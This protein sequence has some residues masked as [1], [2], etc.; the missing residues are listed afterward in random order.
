MK[1]YSVHDE[2]FRQYGRTVAC[3]FFEHFA[4]EA[5]KIALPE[6]G[7]SY[8]ASLAAFETPEAM[9]YYT[10]HFGD[11]DVQIGYCWGQ[12]DTLNALEWHT[13]TEVQCALED[14]I[15]LLGDLREI[16]NGTFDTKRVKAFLVKKGEAVEIYGTTLHYCPAVPAG[17]TFRAVVVL[18]R[19]TNTPLTAKSDDERLIARNKWL[20]CHKESRECTEEG[21]AV[22]LVGKN[23]VIKK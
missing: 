3:P 13:C 23:T 14:M 8:I 1:I 22:G 5:A 20:I 10:A 4:A 16:R 9:D 17:Q 12:N 11:M 7:C 21:R 6:A 15:L 2:K 18:P 19:G